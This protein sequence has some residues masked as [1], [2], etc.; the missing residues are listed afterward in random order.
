M[1]LKSG[2]LSFNFK[3][4]LPKLDKSNVGFHDEFYSKLDEFS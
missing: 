2:G 1:G 4:D 3:L